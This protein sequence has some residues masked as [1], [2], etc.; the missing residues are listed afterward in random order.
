MATPTPQ[1][2]ALQQLRAEDPGAYA[3]AIAELSLAENFDQP[4]RAHR[5][6]YD[7]ADPGAPNIWKDIRSSFVFNPK[8]A[9]EG[10]TAGGGF[11]KAPIN[12]NISQDER[13]KLG[14]AGITSVPKRSF[15]E[16][17]ADLLSR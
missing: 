15:E 17:M 14:A 5:A 9:W 12:P 2:M 1:Q 8:I 10:L 4:L 11:G 7:V 3:D 6:A 13:D 16:M